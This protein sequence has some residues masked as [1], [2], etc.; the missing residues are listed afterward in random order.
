MSSNFW[1]FESF[2]LSKKHCFIAF[3]LDMIVIEQL[4]DEVIDEIGIP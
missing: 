4:L 2:T 1:K 3:I